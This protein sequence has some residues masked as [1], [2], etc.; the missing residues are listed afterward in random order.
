MQKIDIA[1]RSYQ[2]NLAATIHEDGKAGR[3]LTAMAFLT[4]AA[5][6]IYTRVD[7]HQFAQP[8]HF[9]EAAAFPGYMFLVL[10]GVLFYLAALGPNLNIPSFRA[11]NINDSPGLET[12][13]LFFKKIAEL[14]E[15]TWKRRWEKSPDDLQQTLESNFIHE[16]YLIA[17]KVSTKHTLM[18]IGSWCFRFA[19]LF[20]IPLIARVCA[21][22]LIYTQI[23]MGAVFIVFAIVAWVNRP[24]KIGLGVFWLI[25]GV[26][27][28]FII[29]MFKP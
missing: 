17:E 13:L 24:P 19:I 9:V 2:E 1:E 10:L 7:P 12:T 8:V 21:L 5:A 3:I 6:A 4:T 11:K 14:S 22:D 15:P 27:V 23:A 16:A 26:M 25:L 18:S 28:F 20:L 29:G